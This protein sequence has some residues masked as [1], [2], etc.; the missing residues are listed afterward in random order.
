MIVFGWTRCAALSCRFASWSMFA[1]GPGG[2]T[3]DG[4]AAPL[5]PDEQS[6]TSFPA[7]R[8][9]NYLP[10]GGFQVYLCPKKEFKDRDGSS[11]CDAAETPW[12]PGL[13]LTDVVWLAS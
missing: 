1:R 13:R 7:H 4:D 9:S 12:S 11:G 2:A 5:P 6:R 3:G 10:F 8:S